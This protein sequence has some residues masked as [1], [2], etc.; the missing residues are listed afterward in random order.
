[1]WLGGLT[2]V[3]LIIRVIANSTETANGTP[4]ATA[5][6]IA[7]ATPAPKAD[8][9]G[10]QAI[11][12]P[13]ARVAAVPPNAAE[14]QLSKQNEIGPDL[15]GSATAKAVRQRWA[16]HLVVGP[17]PNSAAAAGISPP[18]ARPAMWSSSM[19]SRSHQQ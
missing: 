10:T 1:M 2:A 17:L 19:E 8:T 11:S 14:P 16:A 6:P 4:V 15:G 9:P 5:A 13:P 12:L 3:A 18:P 7:M